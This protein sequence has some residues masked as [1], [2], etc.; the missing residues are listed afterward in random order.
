MTACG[1][2]SGSPESAA[3]GATL[4]HISEAATLPGMLDAIAVVPPTGQALVRRV[5]GRNL[6][7]WFPSLSLLSFVSLV[8]NV[9]NG[10]TFSS[11]VSPCTPPP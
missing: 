11:E 5:P 9:S 6:W 10:T 1:V 8:A 3:I 2:R 4:A 7:L